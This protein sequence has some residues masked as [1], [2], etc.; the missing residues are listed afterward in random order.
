[1][2]WYC[3]AAKL[4]FTTIVQIVQIAGFSSLVKRVQWHS[5]FTV[6]PFSWQCSSIGPPKSLN[7]I[8]VNFPADGWTL[9]FLAIGEGCIRCVLYRLFSGTKR[10]LRVSSAV[11]VCFKNASHSFWYH[12]GSL[13]HTSTC[14]FLCGFSNSLAMISHNLSWISSPCE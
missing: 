12:S 14:F 5:L 9:N 13:V 2:H 8:S 11:T 1:M 6:P 7:N 10:W 4:Q 3:C